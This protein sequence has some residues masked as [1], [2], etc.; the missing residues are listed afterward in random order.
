MWDIVNGVPAL[1]V[2]PQSTL[3]SSQRVAYHPN[4]SFNTG[5]FVVCY[6]SSNNSAVNTTRVIDLSANA[7]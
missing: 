4:V 2:T 3:P 6:D 5:S 7:L 1:L